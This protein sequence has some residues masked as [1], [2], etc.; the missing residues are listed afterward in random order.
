M[1]KHEKHSPRWITGFLAVVRYELLWNL[2]KKKFWGMVVVAFILSTLS[3]L[4]PII[5]S[6]MTGQPI[7][8]NPDYVITLNPLGSLGFFLFAVVTV[9]NSISGEFESGTITLLLTKPISRTTIFLGKLAAAFITLLTTYIILF[10]YVAIVGIA[11]YGPQNNL[12]LLPISL[13]GS[14]VSTFVWIAIVLALGS[15]SKNS[16]IAA[17]GT[18][19][20]YLGASIGSGIISLFSE[21]VWILNYIPGSGATGYIKGLGSQTPFTPGMS[22]STG[23][24]N[25]ATLFTTYLLHPLAN[26]TFYKINMISQVPNITELY[27]EPLSLV[28][29]RT[30]SIAFFYIFIF[31]FIA[32]YA[33]KKAEVLD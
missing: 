30:V 12:H 33:F 26:V 28:L 2:R 5:L 17:I 20:I 16:I 15:L 14:I 21:E 4:L 18:F 29:L 32:W 7:K 11:I 19:G 13:L 25:I 24:D 9:M 22:I 31:L 6:N 27:S 3:L 10:V 23:T 1:K 8:Q